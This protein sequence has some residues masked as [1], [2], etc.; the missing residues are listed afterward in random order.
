MV[1]E[2]GKEL[3]KELA[4]EIIRGV[5]ERKEEDFFKECDTW[6]KERGI[7]R[8]K[9][10]FVHKYADYID[11]WEAEWGRSVNIRYIKRIPLGTNIFPTS[12]NLHRSMSGM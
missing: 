11:I 6:W 3:G 7:F 8:P 5:S 10:L 2:I 1:E 12:N 4:G 9:I